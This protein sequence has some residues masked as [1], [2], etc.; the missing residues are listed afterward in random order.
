MRDLEIVEDEL[1]QLT[2]LEAGPR[3]LTAV[4]LLEQASAE[5]ARPQLDLDEAVGR[6]RRPGQSEIA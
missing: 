4:E 3:V 5:D 2:P 1:P 6:S